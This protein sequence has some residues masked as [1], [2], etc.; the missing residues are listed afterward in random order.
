MRLVPESFEPRVRYHPSYLRV[1]DDGGT[2]GSGDGG[3]VSGGDNSDADQL[4]G[5]RKRAPPPSL[6]L[7]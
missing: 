4:Y 3:D 1:G 6:L 7:I 2:H 5:P